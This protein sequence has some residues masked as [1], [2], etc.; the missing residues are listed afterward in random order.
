MMN[1]C[2]FCGADKDSTP[3]LYEVVSLV[4]PEIWVCVECHS[5][6]EKREYLAKLSLKIARKTSNE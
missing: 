4:L 3:R 6:E 5:S 1:K 2:H